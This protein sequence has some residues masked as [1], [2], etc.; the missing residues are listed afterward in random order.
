MSSVHSAALRELQQLVGHE[1]QL[2]HFHGVVR[3]AAQSLERIVEH[4]TV[5]VTCADEFQGELRASFDRDVARPLTSG[6]L[7]S[8]RCTF[9]LS[10]MGGR[11][12]PGALRLADD[13]FT[14][15]TR[16]DGAKLLLVEI[17]SHCGVLATAGG[18]QYGKLD[19][20]G[21][22]SDCC[23]ALALL[24]AKPDTAAAVRH[25]WFDQLSAFFGE[26]RL[27]A[28][29]ADAGPLRA[30]S[31]AI[32]HAVLQAESAVADVMRE[33]PPT[34]THVLIVSAVLINQP[35][36]DDVI[37]VA[38]HH[39][40]CERGD[41]L[42]EQGFTL[43]STPASLRYDSSS[44]R[45]VVTSDETVDSYSERRVAIHP[46][47]EI[48]RHVARV[49]S[50]SDELARARAKLAAQHLG[51]AHREVERLRREPR[52]W[53]VYA[54][55]LLRGLVQS[56][57]VV[58]PE[59]GLLTMAVQT[60]RDVARAEHVRRLLAKGLSHEDARRVLHDFEAEIQQLS[61]K[62]AQDVLELL[63]AE[64]RPLWK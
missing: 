13:H 35:S 18:K 45:I 25:P 17:V 58:A 26:D 54:R 49:A 20:F 12:E 41:V 46:V 39:L 40:R 27:S 14:S 57:S 21:V 7:L 64:T 2:D 50:A 16:R 9:A 44:G 1:S 22:V 32:V 33:P 15:R 47:H 6:S 42:V 51:R 36:F 23:G 55:P 5:L 53:R 30:L 62:D 34:P 4:G 8:G 59:I 28:L 48:E 3:R 43:R 11:I 60:G 38:V 61:H 52:A 37:P 56:L 63:L 29:R 24:L 31:A 10:N 19:R